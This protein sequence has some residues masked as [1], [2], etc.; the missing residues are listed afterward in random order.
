MVTMLIDPGTQQTLLDWAADGR[1]FVVATV[2][3]VLDSAPLDPGATML[4][5]QD[6]TVEGSVTG[7][8]V[9]GAVV[10][11]AARILADQSEPIVRTY[12][13]SDE[14]A[15]EVGLMCG[16][17]VRL[18]IAEL[19]DAEPVS[20]A[21]AAASEGR[22]AA[23]ATLL[24]GPS[25]GSRLALVDGEPIGTLRGPE[26]LDRSVARDSVGLLE[27]G[28][29]MIRRYGEDGATMGDDVGVFIQS[30]AVAPR[31]VIFGAID[32]SAALARLA[33]PLGYHV[34]ICDARPTFLSGGR[35]SAANE[36][37]RA[38]PDTFL[39]QTSLGLRDAILV[40]TH[41]P[42]F[43]E[44][45]IVAGL[46][47]GAGYIGALGS[48]RTAQDRRERLLAKGVDERELE[49]VVSPCG[50]DIGSATP[51]ETAVSVLAEIIARRA[52]RSGQP[53]VQ[54]GGNIRHHPQLHTTQ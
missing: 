34:T 38:W 6:G 30:F 1:R 53:L 19:R 49:R 27:Q 31:M 4:I 15:G 22:P 45:A 11:E 44:P 36:V 37:V 18:L 48:R 43:D 9:E 39:E 35:F 46:A 3:E 17:T 14:L 42:K 24:E 20:A 23:L 7:G 29:S 13:I 26:L 12:G 2:I 51:A 33:R 5:D 54:T 40:F 28:I 41:D 16:G 47:T 32:F 25:A 52:Q 50:L 21:F 10:E 8:C